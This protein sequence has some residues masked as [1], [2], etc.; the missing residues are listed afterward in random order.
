MILVH[1]VLSL[2]RDSPAGGR[3]FRSSRQRATGSGR[4]QRVQRVQRVP[5]VWWVLRE[6]KPEAPVKERASESHTY[7]RR[8]DEVV[9]AGC[10]AGCSSRCSFFCGSVFGE[11][12]E[13]GLNPGI[14]VWVAFGGGAP[15]P[16]HHCCADFCVFYEVH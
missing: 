5:R 16:E 3:S 13:F 15:F 6:G 4:V 1:L 11:V 12:L 8:Y 10:L 7:K 9:L 2:S 14:R